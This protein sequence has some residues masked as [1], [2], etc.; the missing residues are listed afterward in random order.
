M[1]GF[2]I[3]ELSLVF[4]QL[5]QQ[6]WNGIP[7]PEMRSNTDFAIF[8]ESRYP[9]ILEQINDRRRADDKAP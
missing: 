5:D 9:Q 7:L 3:D 8:F 1:I 6:S 2:A 4:R